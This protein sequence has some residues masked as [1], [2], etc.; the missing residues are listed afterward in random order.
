MR[1]GLAGTGRIGTAHAE[2]LKGFDEVESVV[3]ADV[4]T[5]RATAAGAKLGVEVAASIEG[6]F[7]AGLDGLVVTAATD[8]HPGLIIAAV[9]AGLPVFCE[10]PVAADI[11]GALAVSDRSAVGRAGADRFPPPVRRRL[12]GR[13]GGREHR[14]PGLAA[15]PP[16]DDA[17]PL[18]AAG[19]LRRGVGRDVPRLRRP[20]LRLIRWV[21]GREVDEVYAVGGNRGDRSFAEVSDVDTAAVTLALDDG[22][23]ALVSNTRYNGAGYDV[24]LEVLGRRPTSRSAWTT[25]PAPVG[26]AGR[27]AAAG[28]GRTRVSWSASARRTERSW[29][30]S[31]TS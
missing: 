14:G 22:T 8:A 30:R 27:P 24:R 26:R 19:G 5:A 18:P 25:G 7:A 23:L 2:T 12:Q 6:L 13:A 20:R 28:P 16:G 11:P 17:R 21:T 3:V 29:R 15:H 9:D 10:K 4:D 1:L 31:S